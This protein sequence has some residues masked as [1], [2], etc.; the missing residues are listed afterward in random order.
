M[1]GVAIAH[2]W[3]HYRYGVFD[4]IG[5]NGD[6]LYPNGY[7]I[8]QPEAE[9]LPT[10]CTNEPLKGEWMGRYVSILFKRV[11]FDSF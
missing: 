4:E 2:E 5:V 8:T 9:I 7:Q 1:K 10:S 11:K 6:P 3:F